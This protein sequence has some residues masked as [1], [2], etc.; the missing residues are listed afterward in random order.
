MK[1]L[2]RY[3]LFE[4]MDADL[5]C[6]IPTFTNEI[7]ETFSHLISNLKIISLPYA[8]Y[9]DADKNPDFHIYILHGNKIEKDDHEFLRELYGLHDIINNLYNKE[10]FYISL[11]NGKGIIILFDYNMTIHDG[12]VYKY[13]YKSKNYLS[14]IKNS[15]LYRKLPT[16]IFDLLTRES[17]ELI[18]GIRTDHE[19][20]NLSLFD[21]KYQ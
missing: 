2:T 3:N 20:S 11:E 13:S 9:G 14:R 15:F 18:S 12:T 16:D 8:Y 7:C 6:K 21:W 17:S 5:N 10:Y 4:Q 19:S 1:H